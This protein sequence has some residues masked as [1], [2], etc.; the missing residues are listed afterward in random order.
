MLPKG[1]FPKGHTL[2]SA[3][4]LIC[5]D[6]QNPHLWNGNSTIS[7]VCQMGCTDQMRSCAR[8]ESSVKTVE[9]LCQFHCK[10]HR[11]KVLGIIVFTIKSWRQVSDLMVKSYRALA[12]RG[13]EFLCVTD[14]EKKSLNI[15]I[16]QASEK[17]KLSKTAWLNQKMEGLSFTQALS[18]T[19]IQ[20]LG[21][22]DTQ[23]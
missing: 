7:P 4:H 17:T 16:P 19:F 12:R 5:S 22:L 10:I 18:S 2:N 13:P 23:I 9:V 3:T 15:E 21:Y 1:T 11:L 14:K 20:Y 8:R 6:S